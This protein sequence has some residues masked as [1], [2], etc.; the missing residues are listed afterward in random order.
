MAISSR[1]GELARVAR[2]RPVRAVARTLAHGAIVRSVPPLATLRTDIDLFEGVEQ[3]RWKGATPAFKPLLRGSTTT[4]VD[5][6]ELIRAQRPTRLDRNPTR[7]R[8][9]K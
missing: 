2:E 4:A 1:F 5:Q 6:V 8:L 9:V 7:C 3:L